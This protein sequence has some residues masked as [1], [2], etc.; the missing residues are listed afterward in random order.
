MR[1]RVIT[2]VN[3]KGGVAK[4]TTTI[5]LAAG[6]ARRGYLILVV[7]LDPQQNTTSVLLASQDVEPNLFQVLVQG[8]EAQA[9][10]HQPHRGFE[11][12]SKIRV[13]PSHIDLTAADLLLAGRVG[14]ENLL[15]KQLA[16]LVEDFDF[17]LVDTPP[18][19]GLLTVNALTATD[20]TIVPVSVNYFALQGVKMLK[21]T[22]RAVREN[23][24]RPT[25]EINHVLCTFYDSSTNISH[26][27][28]AAVRE[29][30]GERVFRTVIPK[31]VDLEYAHSS[32]Q[33]IFSYAPRSAGAQAYHSLV[34]ELLGR[35][36]YD[37]KTRVE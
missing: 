32:K 36:K 5:N 3:Q 31:N 7:D 16:P 30:F 2:I 12:R 25:L 17:I 15:P 34:D 22:I 27:A 4:S 14:R 10:V 13:L 29:T 23:L 19:L 24:D 11:E 37:P 35:M 18:S 8:T 26:D 28:L 6:L 20:G 1:A 9:A 33:S 21:D